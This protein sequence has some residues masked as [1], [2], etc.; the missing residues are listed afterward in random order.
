MRAYLID[1]IASSEMEKID[2]YLKKNAITAALEGLF[3]VKIPTN[4]LNS[5][6]SQHNAC[7]PFGFAVELGRDQIKL[8][9]LV[10]SLKNLG[11]ECQ[12]YCTPQQ[13]DFIS[14]FSHNMIENLG[15]RT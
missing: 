11:C 3:W 10:R 9:F 1:E 5:I 13:R 2:L 15:I 12:G 6:Q 14:L 7:Q 8:E 4:L